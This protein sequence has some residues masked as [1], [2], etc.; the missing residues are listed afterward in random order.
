M[1]GEGVT[2]RWFGMWYSNTL[3]NF[4]FTAVGDYSQ[5]HEAK[6]PPSPPFER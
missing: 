2:E 5:L 4:G 1:L 3:A 6:S